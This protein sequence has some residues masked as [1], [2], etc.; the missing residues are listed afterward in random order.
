[1]NGLDYRFSASGDI[2]FTTV[3]GP[4]PHVVPSPE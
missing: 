4:E 2:R 1:M 3:Y